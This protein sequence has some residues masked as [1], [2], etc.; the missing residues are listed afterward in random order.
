MS[1][2]C[3]MCHSCASG[4]RII[5]VARDMRAGSDHLLDI[6]EFQRAV[7]HFEPGEIVM[8]RGFTIG[9]EIELAIA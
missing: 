1:V 8:L 4:S 3:W 6:G 5:G 2:A 7:L 9:G